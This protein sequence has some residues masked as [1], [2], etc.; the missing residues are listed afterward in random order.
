MCRMV[1]IYRSVASIPKQAKSNGA[2][3]ITPYGILQGKEIKELDADKQPI[4]KHD[5]STPFITHHIK[6]EKGDTLYLFTDGYADQF[7]GPKGKK[8]KYRTMQDKILSISDRPMDEQRHLLE[9]TIDEWRGG[10]EQV[11]DIL[12]IGIRV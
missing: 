1:W 10:L 11:D 6:L 3:H 4:G 5:K 7:G 8:F 9:T 12:V 2:V